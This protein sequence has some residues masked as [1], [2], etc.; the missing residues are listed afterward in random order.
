MNCLIIEGGGFK[1]GFTTGI[2]DAFQISNYRPFDFYIGVSGGA[3]ATSYFLSEQYRQ[4]ISAIKLLASDEQFTK[5]TRS[6]GDQGYMDID[7]LRQVANQKVPLD[8]DMAFRSTQQAKVFFVATHRNTGVAHY[9]QPIPENWLRGPPLPPKFAPPPPNPNS[10]KIS[11][12]SKFLKI[13]S[14]ENRCWKSA[15]P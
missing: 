2:L 3:I 11:P 4:C 15:E 9:L 10:F 14:W 5:F 6:F 8:L 1:T 7:Y 13:S 12:R